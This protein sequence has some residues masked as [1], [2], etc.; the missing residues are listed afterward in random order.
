MQPL[1]RE[2]L[3]ARL[4]RRESG[5]TLERD[6]YVSP[7]AFA[8]DME[9]I[10]YGEWLHVGHVASVP[11][12]GD[13]FTLA[14]GDYQ[15][16]IVRGEDEQLRALHNVCRHR[17]SV[18]CVEASGSVRRRLV[19]PYH[20]WAYELDGSLARARR[21][22]SDVDP[23]SLG[24][25]PLA[26]EVVAGLIYVCLAADPPDFDPM[27]R[28]IEPYLAP[29][30]LASAQIAAVT[31]DIEAGNWKLVMENNRECY[32]CRVAHPE[33][34]VSFPEAPLHSGGGSGDDLAKQ[35]RLIDDAEAIGLPSRY[36][37]APDAQYRIMRMPLE[38]DARSMTADGEPAVR[39]RFG[40]LGADNIGDVL[41][42]HYPSTWNHFMADHALTFAI[43]PVGPTTTRL[44]TT[45]L[46]PEGAVAGID[47][48]VDSLT[49][50]WRAT[51]AQD[52]RLVERTQL[53][54]NSPAFRPGPY[55]PVEEDG[56]MG[57][58][59]WYVT[60][61]MAAGPNKH[62]Q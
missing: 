9:T 13:Y 10:W 1:T 26:C 29:Y 48:D 38:G 58:V 54:V 55:A 53:G 15:I 14:V 19:C 57:F 52:A 47:Y 43:M 44:T 35:Q 27:R 37:I 8:L 40:A 23:A 2:S 51:N 7:E 6:F 56:V 20:Q 18:V 4:A 41:L 11:R 42:Y 30:E 28:L 17:G 49:E 60:R 22:E 25:Q 12:A 46:V 61:M 31:V 32:H 62:P 36:E 21:F 45:W 59:D 33:L 3:A 24:L 16:V 34:C 50:V 39:R 5:Y